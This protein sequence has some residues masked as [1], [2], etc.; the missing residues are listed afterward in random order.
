MIQ[1]LI[2]IACS[3]ITPAE[4]GAVLGAPVGP[5]EPQTSADGTVTC[6]YIAPADQSLRIEVHPGGARAFQSY[7]AA[8]QKAPQ[9]RPQK[10]R[11][12]GGQAV[13]Q[14]GQLVVLWRDH[15]LVLA[16]GL[17]LDE[18]DRLRLSMGLAR[19]ALSRAN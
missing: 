2:P 7:V 19:K 18:K 12:L 13:F 4:A 1:L 17:A 14:A 9:G 15:F 6:H 5:A 8:F 11:G 10:L 16:V 3:L